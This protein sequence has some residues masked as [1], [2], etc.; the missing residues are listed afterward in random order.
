MNNVLSW[1]WFNRGAILSVAVFLAACSDTPPVDQP[2]EP[3]GDFK[4][5][6]VLVITKN[7]QKGPLSREISPESLE[8]ALRPE[9]E[10]FLTSYTGDRF[11]HVAVVVDAYVLAVPGVPLVASPKSALILSVEVWDDAKRRK[12]TEKPAQI[13]VL[14]EFSGKTLFGSG[15]TQS[16]EQ[17]LAGLA[18]VGSK[19]VYDWM[20][21]NKYL[22]EIELKAKSG[23]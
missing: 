8:T 5:G 23:A 16:K 17:Q 7:V 21:E 2:L 12:I 15:L 9:I 6:S 19:A 22:F 13:V 20:V 14:E 11:Y 3:L 1:P 4:M 10:K 18:R